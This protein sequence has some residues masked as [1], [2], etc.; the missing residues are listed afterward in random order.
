MSKN[1]SET[2]KRKPGRPPNRAACEVLFQG[3]Y[4]PPERFT[5]ALDAAQ[6]SQDRALDKLLKQPVHAKDSLENRVRRS[7]DK[8]TNAV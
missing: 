2:G 5:D 1:P 6:D 3:K 7:L 8:L 4:D